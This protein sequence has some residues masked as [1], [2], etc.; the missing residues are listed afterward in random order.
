MSNPETSAPNTATQNPD[1]ISMMSRI[2]SLENNICVL[3]SGG[4]NICSDKTLS[5]HHLTAECPFS[6]GFSCSG[7][8]YFHSKGRL[9]RRLV[10]LYEMADDM[11]AEADRQANAANTGITVNHTNECVARITSHLRY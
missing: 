4:G 10:S 8:G 3:Q 11:L 7:P 9:I 6:N 5:I 1:P 2:S